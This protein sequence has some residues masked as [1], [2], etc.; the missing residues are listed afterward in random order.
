MNEKNMAHGY[1]AFIF[2]EFMMSDLQ[3]GEFSPSRQKKDFEASKFW[4]QVMVQSVADALT[5]LDCFHGLAI[6]IFPTQ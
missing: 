5:S 2:A 3:T 1:F 6:D 4:G